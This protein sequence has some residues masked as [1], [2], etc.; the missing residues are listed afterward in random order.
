ML[1]MKKKDISKTVIFLHLVKTAGTTLNQ[2]LDREYANILSFYIP[3]ESKE[4]FDGF[5]EKLKTGNP[6]LIRGHFE[7]G[8]HVFLSRPFIYITLLREPVARVISEYFYI[9]GKTDHPLFDQVSAK[10]ISIADFVKNFLP[11]NLQTRKISGLTFAKNSG[12]PQDLEINADNML[13]IA[14]EN[15]DKY[16]AIVGLTE[17]FDETLILLKRELRWD[18]PF[19]TRQNVTRKK[20]ARENMPAS[21]IEIIKEHNQLDV[22]LYEYTRQLFNEKIRQQG[23]SFFKEVEKFK[24]LNKDRE[25]YTGDTK[26]MEK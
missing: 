8:W 4:L 6:G 23:K 10:N 22:E 3:R 14:K 25:R 2:V 18:W 7:W 24:K 19:Y 5:K 15:L 13:K 17:K 20:V 26:K 12:I 16:F 1:I 21:T 9:L 11:P